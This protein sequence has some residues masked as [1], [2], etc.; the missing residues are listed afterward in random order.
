[1]DVD[2]QTLARWPGRDR[3]EPTR[4]HHGYL[5]LKPLREALVAARGTYIQPGARLLDVGAGVM[6]YFP[7][8]AD[9]VSEYVGND[10]EAGPGL[11]SISPIS[12]WGRRSR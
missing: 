7:L 11:R 5:I 1:M 4:R 9:L 3:R 12:R 10:V 8:F 2:Q 6:P